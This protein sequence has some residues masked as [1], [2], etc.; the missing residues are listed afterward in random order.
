MEGNANR[1]CMGCMREKPAGEVCPACGWRDGTPP[2]SLLELAPGT[3]INGLYLL[4]RVV[5]EGGFGITYIGWDVTNARRVAVKEYFPR[6]AA[7]RT[8]GSSL[9]TPL[10]PQSAGDFEY[11]L[12]R[13]SEESRVL[14]MFHDHPCI[15]S[16]LDFQSAN[17]T[18][19]LV[20]EYLEGKTLG[21]YL[22][23][24]N[25]RIAGDAALSVTMRVL[26][27]LREV[28]HHGLLH[29]DIS[30]DNI[31]LTR[32]NGVKLLDFGAARFAMG[33]RSQNLSIILKPGYAPPEQYLT[34]GRQGPQTDLYATAATMYRSVT[35]Q[36]PPDA[37]ERQTQDSLDPPNRL[38]AGLP[39]HIENALMRAMSLKMRDRFKTAQDF[40]SALA[41]GR[42]TG[43]RKERQ[44]G[45]TAWAAYLV[46]T[47]VGAVIF[48]AYLALVIPGHFGLWGK[49]SPLPPPRQSSQLPTPTPIP[50]LPPATAPADSPADSPAAPAQ[51]GSA[52]QINYGTF[53]ARLVNGRV[54]ADVVF[55]ILPFEGH[56]GCAVLVLADE[57]GKY[58][59]TPA[60]KIF[61]VL[62]D[63][64]SSDDKSAV[65]VKFEA[66]APAIVGT[67]TKVSAQTVLFGNPC[68]VEDDPFISKS[69]LIP[70]RP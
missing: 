22:R 38:G 70:L 47:L 57:N 18:A 25:G 10:S 54:E 30:P 42:A 26:D 48:L 32:S 68:N 56:H 46:G 53:D 69:V 16:C 40:Q 52:L 36:V 6:T 63:F 55:Q 43:P 41:G 39:P 45:P 67:M 5:G 65:E 64:T 1:R 37:I 11:G 66:D 23:E 9:V 27:G 29:R 3:N 44:P 62:R 2:A 19:Y 33:E 24:R 58:L 17:G 14:T 49:S 15:V 20:M 61:Q 31:F 4:G 21:S 59:K 8:T 35:G 60:D 28:H 7:T 13:F 12:K 34:R 50:T 51:K